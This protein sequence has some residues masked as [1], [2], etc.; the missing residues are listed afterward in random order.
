MK[1]LKE[2]YGNEQFNPRFLGLFINPFYFAR[3][4]LYQNICS[5]ASHISGKTLDVGCGQKPY[6]ALFTVTDYIGL[7]IEGRQDSSSKKADYY[8]DG[9]FFPFPDNTFD[10]ILV[11]QVFEHVFNPTEFLSEISRVLK[12]QGILLMTVPFVWDEHEQPFDYAR[13]SSFGLIHLLQLHGFEITEHRK[14]IDDIRVVFQLISGYIYKKLSTQS[15]L[16]NL[17]LTFF[18]IA[19]INIAGEVFG[20]ILPGNLDLYLDNIV[21]ATKVK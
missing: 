11:N 16:I 9:H 8:Y 15:Q 14:S 18:L 7:E 10:S 2:I 17:I 4:G 20:C 6:Q 19:P 21:V 5:L 13:Y 3:K 1:S 12:D